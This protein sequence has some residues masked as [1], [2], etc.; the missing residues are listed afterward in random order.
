MPSGIEVHEGIVYAT[1]HATSRFY[2]FDLTG[3]LVRTLD[4]GLPAGSL[5]GFTFGPDG[6]LYFVDLRSSRVYR[7]DPI[8]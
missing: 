6:K 3:R 5:A 7:I 1:D 4:T 2:A 8:L